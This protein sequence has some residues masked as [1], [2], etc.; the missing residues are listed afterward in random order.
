[1]RSATSHTIAKTDR[2]RRRDKEISLRA[3]AHDLI[4]RVRRDLRDWAHS[5]TEDVAETAQQHDDKVM[6][7]GATAPMRFVVSHR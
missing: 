2:K 7:A 4:D 6:K 5:V 3:S 1:M